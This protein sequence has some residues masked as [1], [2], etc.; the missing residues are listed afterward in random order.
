MSELVMHT[1]RYLKSHR[2]DALGN[3][4]DTFCGRP[5]AG[6]VWRWQGDGYGQLWLCGDHLRPAELNGPEECRWRHL[7]DIGNYYDDD[8]LA[9]LGFVRGGGGDDDI[10]G[11]A[12]LSR[13][14]D[15]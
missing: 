10:D 13:I 6:W 11:E 8:E 9:E 14:Q 7:A 1:C 12:D 15:V 5:A 3:D 2:T 4:L